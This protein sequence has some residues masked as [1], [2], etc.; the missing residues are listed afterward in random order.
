[1]LSNQDLAQL[2][3]L[4]LVQAGFQ[5]YNP[6]APKERGFGVLPDTGADSVTVTTSPSDG[7]SLE[8]LHHYQ[9]A[10]RP[11]GAQHNLRIILKPIAGHTG[12]DIVESLIVE[13][14]PA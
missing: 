6:R 2:V 1:M 3:G 5:P 14:I 7:E 9:V 8:E 4:A 12:A 11:L 13:P 10:L